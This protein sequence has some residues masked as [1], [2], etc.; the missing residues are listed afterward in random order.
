MRG[1]CFELGREA[2]SVRYLKAMEQLANDVQDQELQTASLEFHRLIP[3]ETNGVSAIGSRNS[4]HLPRPIGSYC[5]IGP[6]ASS[7]CGVSRG[8]RGRGKGQATF[9]VGKVACPP[10][11]V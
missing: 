3:V 5:L 1:N 10:I 2:Q 9:P 4:T 8:Q 6:A 7:S 11:P